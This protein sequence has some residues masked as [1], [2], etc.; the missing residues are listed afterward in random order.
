MTFEA[1][2]G[3]KY[4]DV[5]KGNGPAAEKGSLVQVCLEA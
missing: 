4:Y 5:L 2:D 1:A 3:L